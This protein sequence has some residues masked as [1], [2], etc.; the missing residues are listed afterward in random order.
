MRERQGDIYWIEAAALR[1]GRAGVAHPHVVVQDD[2]LNGSRIPTVVVC[3]LT[4]RLA[5]AHEPGNVLLDVGE[6][7]LPQQSAVVVSQVC[8]VDR[9]DL[10]AYVGRL[11]PERI[12]QIRA[13]MQFVQR[14]VSR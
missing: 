11:G 4:T 9:A 3:S 14:L 1:P 2:L 7:G 12:A 13:G 10:G 5:V 8:V 6:A